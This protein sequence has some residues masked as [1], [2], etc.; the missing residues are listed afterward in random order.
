LAWRQWEWAKGNAE[1]T[2]LQNVRRWI[3]EMKK[4]GFIFF[5]LAAAATHAQSVFTRVHADLTLSVKCISVLDSCNAGGYC[6]DSVIYYRGLISLKQHDITGAK[7]AVKEL[8]KNYPDFNEVNYLNGLIHFSQ[9]N[10]GKAVNDFSAVIQKNNAH[11][12]ALYNRSISFGLMEEYEKAIDDLNACIVL[13]PAY[14]Q[15]FYSRAYWNEYLGNYPDAIRDYENSIHLEPEHYD[16][17]LGLAY[18]YQR[19]KNNE[20]SCEVINSAIK[21]GSQIAEEVKENFCK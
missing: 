16:A 19:L 15:A 14:G 18:I 11:I 6:K 5:L 9:K 21:A 17:Y 4:T 10:Y 8:Q 1:G 2:R 20:K 12:K 3:I 7:L 13:K